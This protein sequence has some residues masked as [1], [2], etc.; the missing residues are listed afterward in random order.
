MFLFPY[1]YWHYKKIPFYLKNNSLQIFDVAISQSF[2]VAKVYGFSKASINCA[3]G[4]S[5][6]MYHI[7]TEHQLPYFE[8]RLRSYLIWLKIDKKL[9]LVFIV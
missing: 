7:F 1:L 8:K 5:L 4:L 3:E 2:E 6:S 9:I